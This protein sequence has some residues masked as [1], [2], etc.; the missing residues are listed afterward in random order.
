MTMVQNYY[1]VDDFQQLLFDGDYKLP[2]NVL[3]V[4]QYLEQNV[5]VPVDVPDTTPVVSNPRKY[6]NQNGRDGRD[7]R[8]GRS[9]C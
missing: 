5:V 1:T 2:E 8:L 3:S 6:D 4:I 9:C 7:G